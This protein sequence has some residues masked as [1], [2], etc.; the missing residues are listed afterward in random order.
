MLT[1][2]LATI[3]I[4]FIVW[5]CSTAKVRPEN[6]DPIA[7]FRPTKED[8]ILPPDRVVSA[9]M[10]GICGDQAISDSNDSIIR[11]ITLKLDRRQLD[12]KFSYQVW[13]DCH[14][15]FTRMFL[16]LT[17]PELTCAIVIDAIKSIPVC[18]KL[19]SLGRVSDLADDMSKYFI[20]PTPNADN[21]LTLDTKKSIF[22]ELTPTSAYSMSVGPWDSEYYEFKSSEVMP[23]RIDIDQQLMIGRFYA[24]SNEE[25]KNAR[26]TIPNGMKLPEVAQLADSLNMMRNLVEETAEQSMVRK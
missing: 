2:Q 11:R 26:V 10:R 22:L 6:E 24:V 1:P 8:V 16:R 5:G 4:A 14:S 19:D 23:L 20:M 3:L 18:R 25:M 17:K 13:I 12:D 15:S 21:L 7:T 9:G